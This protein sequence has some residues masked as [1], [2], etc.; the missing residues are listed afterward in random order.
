MLREEPKTDLRRIDRIRHHFLKLNRNERNLTHRQLLE[1][2]RRARDKSIT[3][4]STHVGCRITRA[5]RRQL[6]ALAETRGMKPSALMR[7][8]INTYLERES[9]EW[10]MK[11]AS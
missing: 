6:E 3:D 5:D 9:I 10:E 11:I 4:N 8:V 7:E 2:R 1:I